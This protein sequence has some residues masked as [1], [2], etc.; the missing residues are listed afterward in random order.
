M[1]D[2]PISGQGSGSGAG[3]ACAPVGGTAQDCG[4][5]RVDQ[6]VE[7]GPTEGQGSRAGGAPQRQWINLPEH[8]EH[9]DHGR[10]IYLKAHIATTGPC[11]PA[12]QT[13]YW[14]FTPGGDNRAGLNSVMRA[15]LRR[16]ADPASWLHTQMSGTTG[17]DGWTDVVQF[18]LSRYGG[19]QF[20]VA[21]TENGECTGGQ[22]LGPFQGWRRLW[23]E[24]DSMRNNPEMNRPTD[25]ACTSYGDIFYF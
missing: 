11:S 10:V 9:H 19:D 7:V 1:C 15:G 13:V 8:A 3:V 17:A 21:A 5:Y 2:P 22:S 18:H 4:T 12:G 16:A 14:Y 25:A 20:T 23:C 6:L 24:I